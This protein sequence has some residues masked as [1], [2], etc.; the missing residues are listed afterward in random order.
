MFHSSHHEHL[1][2]HC[3]S[4]FTEARP[5]SAVLA[6]HRDGWGFAFAKADGSV[7]FGLDNRPA[8]R[9]GRGFATPMKKT[10]HGPPDVQRFLHG[11]P[12]DDYL[13]VGFCL[14]KL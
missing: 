10:E 14:G 13:V 6:R 9:A 4:C 2:L 12:P 3:S 11:G 5:R 8:R 7:A 1:K